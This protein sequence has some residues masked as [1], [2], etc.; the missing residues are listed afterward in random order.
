[1]GQ[2]RSQPGAGAAGRLWRLDAAPG[3]HLVLPD[4]VM[5]LVWDGR[6]LVLAG[7][8]TVAAPVH[9]PDGVAAWGLRLAPGVAHAVLG[10]S[11]LELRGA[12]VPLRE[13]AP[14]GAGAVDALHAD[15]AA[16]LCDI[17]RAL[18][19][20]AAADRELI[21]LAGSL[22]RAARAGLGVP[23][24][25]DRH[26]VSERALRRVSHRVFGYG[27]KTL[28][29][30]HRF[31]RALRLARTGLPLARV[32]V[33]AGYADQA[34]LGREVKRLSGRTPAVLLGRTDEWAHTGDA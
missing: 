8:D 16:G 15:P 2:V 29:S 4:G 26:G 31:Q 27:P 1:M 5:D 33:T 25:A 11:A 10:V 3:T 12:R 7:P 28:A 9:Y 20:R 30:I 13:L 34:H 18:G 24:I 32:A 19:H 6:D 21:G 17:V 23:A 22:D 14:V